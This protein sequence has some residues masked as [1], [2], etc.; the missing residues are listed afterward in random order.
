[1]L[2]RTS[3]GGPIGGTTLEFPNLVRIFAARAY[4]HV[5]LKIHPLLPQRR[6]FPIGIVGAGFIVNDC[7]LVAYHRKAGF[8][9]V[10]IASRTKSKAEPVEHALR[11]IGPRRQDPPGERHLG[12]PDLRDYR[13]ARH[14]ALRG[15]DLEQTRKA[16]PRKTR[17]EFQCLTTHRRPRTTANEVRSV[18]PLDQRIGDHGVV[19]VLEYSPRPEKILE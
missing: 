2:R 1:M 9:P 19:F 16:P 10:A 6:D 13:Y 17:P 15:V 5:D 14:P 8:N 18:S 11:S 12:E 4:F 7:H 3:G